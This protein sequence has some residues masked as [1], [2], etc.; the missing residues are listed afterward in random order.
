MDA[1]EPTPKI[2]RVHKIFDGLRELQTQTDRGC[3]IVGA[4]IVQDYLKALVIYRLPVQDAKALEMFESES[5]GVLW[6]FGA[7]IKIAHA[8]GLIGRDVLCDLD[9]IRDMR[10]KFAHFVHYKH[11]KQHPDGLVT[12]DLKI[13][14]DWVL[15]LK[16]PRLHATD[17]TDT[18]NRFVDTCLVLRQILG[19]ATSAIEPVAFPLEYPSADAAQR[20]FV[21]LVVVAGIRGPLAGVNERDKFLPKVQFAPQ[22]ANVGIDK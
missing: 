18:R 20:S 17:D 4:A 6:S 13:I 2:S 19:N 14:K 21:L 10:N 16:C 11:G 8:L 1:S 12:F 22:S 9:R 7:Q 3:A 15:V 5:H